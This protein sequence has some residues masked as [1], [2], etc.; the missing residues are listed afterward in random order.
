MEIKR[1]FYLNKLIDRQRN[2]LVKIITGI[3]RCGKS[4]LL[5]NLFYRFLLGSGVGEDHII[6]ILLD[7]WA[8]KEFRNSDNLYKYGKDC[9]SD[10]DWYYILLDEVR[11]VSE[12]DDVLNGFLHIG[13]ADT[14]VT[15]SNS[16]FLSK[17]IITEFIG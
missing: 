15:G 2:G 10:K 12:F 14:Y 13:N 4:Y 17:D 6:R 3:R 16:E 5:F 7:D 9:I 8:N 11:F 1:D